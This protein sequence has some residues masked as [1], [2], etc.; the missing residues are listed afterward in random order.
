MAVVIANQLRKGFAGDPLFDGVSLGRAPRPALARRPERGGQDDL[1]R[2]LS[3]ELPGWRAA[4]LMSSRGRAS[5]SDQRPPLEQGLTLR[6]YV[7]SGAADLI[8]LEEE[9]RSLRQAM[10]AGDHDQATLARYADAQA[11]LEHAG[12]YAWRDRTAGVV[13]GLGFTDA[14]LDRLLDTFSGGELTR[15]SLARALAGDP[16][17]VLWTS[18]RTTW[19]WR[20]SSG[21]SASSSLSTPP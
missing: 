7:L 9:L 5:R 11:R 15:A 20:A 1:A 8:A 21:S 17:L 19:T 16:D 3:G 2:M 18:R 14:D 4:R 10:A 6:E 12:G 13:R